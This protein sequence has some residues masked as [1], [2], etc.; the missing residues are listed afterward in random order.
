ML[1]NAKLGF[2]NILKNEIYTKLLICKKL[3]EIQREMQRIKLET[4]QAK[5]NY[6]K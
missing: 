3:Y 6:G 1:A 4:N 2:L 5:K